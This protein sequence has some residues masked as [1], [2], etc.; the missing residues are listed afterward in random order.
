MRVVFDTNVLISAFIANGLCCELLEHCGRQ[1]TVVV[2]DFLLL[3]FRERLVAKFKYTAEEAEAAA[4]LIQSV[5]KV[6]APLDLGSPVC[7]DHDDDA[8]IGTGVAGNA[9]CIV[10]GDSDL[11]VLKAYR[12]IT[13]LRPSEF[14]EFEAG[15]HE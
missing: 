1:H 9:A 3:E 11:L 14:V 4:G 12:G 7:R 6:V 8:V 10:T 2:S 5:A 15:Y 13:I